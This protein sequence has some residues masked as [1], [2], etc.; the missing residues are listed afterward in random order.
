MIINNKLKSRTQNTC[1]KESHSV[2][3]FGI[4]WPEF[5]LVELLFVLEVLFGLL[6]LLLLLLL[7]FKIMLLWPPGGLLALVVLDDK[8]GGGGMVV[9]G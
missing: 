9:V 1:K 3:M 8:G 7:L 5:E 6:L 4:S 2:T